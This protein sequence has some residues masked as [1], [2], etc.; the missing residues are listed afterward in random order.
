M[1]K[2]PDILVDTSVWV[3]YFRHGNSQLAEYLT[4]DRVR[5]HPLIIGE[6]ACGTPPK[7]NSTL[8]AL[9]QLRQS[10]AVGIQDCMVFID[11]HQ[12]YGYGC[13]L[14]DI[15]LLYSALQTQNVCLWTL[16]KRL[17]ALAVRFAIEYRE[18]LS[19]PSL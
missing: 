13:G 4:R 7:R 3:D 10:E 15:M 2:M 18:P 14:V 19:P 6:I 1:T 17:H 9:G 8:Y 16:D 5:V 11:A 12:L